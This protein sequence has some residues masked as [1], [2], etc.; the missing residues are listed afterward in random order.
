MDLKQQIGNLDDDYTC[1]IKLTGIQTIGEYV[2]DTK[3]YL[4]EL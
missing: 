3:R 4:D 2:N 1:Q